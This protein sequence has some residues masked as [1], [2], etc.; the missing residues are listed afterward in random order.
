MCISEDYVQK[1][2]KEKTAKFLIN[3][4]ENIRIFLWK[5]FE[6][7]QWQKTEQ[8]TQIKRKKNPDRT[9]AEY[10]NRISRANQ[11]TPK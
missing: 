2:M 7:T 11:E 1:S 10:L 8:V 5:K 6:E 9:R 4:K 3:H